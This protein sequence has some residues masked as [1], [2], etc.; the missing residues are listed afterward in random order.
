MVHP[1]TTGLVA[2]P[3]YPGNKL[4]NKAS[5]RVSVPLIKELVN[6][7]RSLII[8]LVSIDIGQSNADTADDVFMS[9]VD[10]PPRIW[11]RIVGA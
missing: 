3:G 11:P 5:K 8:T 1:S 4:L 6:E 10:I 7:T 9:Q 2:Y